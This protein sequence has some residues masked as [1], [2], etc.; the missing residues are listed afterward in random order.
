MRVF[1]V[2]FSNYALR[3]VFHIRIRVSTELSRCGHRAAAHDYAYRHTGRRGEDLD[4]FIR[5]GSQHLGGVIGEQPSAA[6]QQAY[7]ALDRGL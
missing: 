1:L 6:E 2:N 7:Q 5:R 4:A 3:D